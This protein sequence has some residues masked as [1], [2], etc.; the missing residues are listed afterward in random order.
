MST[1][2]DWIAFYLVTDPYLS[3]GS[4]L[5]HPSRPNGWSKG[6][7][8]LLQTMSF[9]LLSSE[10][11][12]RPRECGVIR[13]GSFQG[14]RGPEYDETNSVSACRRRRTVRGSARPGKAATAPSVAAMVMTASCCA[15]VSAALPATSS[16]ARRAVQSRKIAPAWSRR[17]SSEPATVAAATA[18]IE[19]LFDDRLRRTPSPRLHHPQGPRTE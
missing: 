1:G 12:G 2:C 4:V 19:E 6:W 17:S 16:P 11:G 15:D 7:T 3:T 10:R 8:T 13:P 18:E 14:T 9:V 5:V